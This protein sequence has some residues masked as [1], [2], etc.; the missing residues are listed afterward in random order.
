[1]LFGV[2]TQHWSCPVEGRDGAWRRAMETER[3]RDRW[4]SRDV[5]WCNDVRWKT[6]HV[7]HLHPGTPPGAIDRRG[8]ANAN[9]CN[10]LMRAF[11]GSGAHQLPLS[12]H[13]TRW[14]GGSGTWE[15]RTKG[16][17]CSDLTR[18]CSLRV[19]Y[20][21]RTRVLSA[22]CVQSII[23][24]HEQGGLGN[25]CDH[26]SVFFWISLFLRDI[27]ACWLIVSAPR[28]SCHCL[29]ISFHLRD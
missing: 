17:G 16:A 13:L 8:G 27:Q 15:R 22:L 26:C 4:E 18:D 14:D 23:M 2:V 9:R 28:Y 5:R 7:E 24:H 1:M 25:V 12:P 6:L 29:G 20:V 11:G 10:A 21:W 19:M 3:Q